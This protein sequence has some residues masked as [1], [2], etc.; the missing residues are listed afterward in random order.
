[1][2]KLLIALA[3]VLLSL[4]ARLPDAPALQPDRGDALADVG[5]DDEDDDEDDE[6]DRA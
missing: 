4:T 3:L 1:M 5:D 6:E 2:H